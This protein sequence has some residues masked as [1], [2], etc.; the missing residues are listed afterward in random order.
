MA[1]TATLGF[2][3]GCTILSFDSANAFNTMNRPRFLPALAD[4]VPT[5][6]SYA[7]NLYAR[8][9]PKFMFPLDGGGAEVVGVRAGSTA[10]L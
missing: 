10:R 9:P 5:V 1:L 7:A 8:E 2:Q 3:E 4:V 6:V